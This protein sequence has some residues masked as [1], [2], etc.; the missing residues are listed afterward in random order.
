MKP[1]DVPDDLADDA[2]D[3]WHEAPRNEHG[4]VILDDHMRYVLAA[5]L[6]AHERRVREQVAAEIEAERSGG[7][8]HWGIAMDHA[9]RI[10]RGES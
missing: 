9:A 4:L 2:V 8:E 6:P 5:V 1:E 3:A 10:A 7:T